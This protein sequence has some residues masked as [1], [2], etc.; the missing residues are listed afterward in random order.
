[1]HDNNLLKRQ[2]DD[3]LKKKKL[4]VYTVFMLMCIYLL[5]NILFDNN[6]VIKYFELKK[7]EQKLIFEIASL[8]KENDMIE[9]EIQLLRDNPFYF[10][11]HARENLNLAGPN[12]F[13]FLYEQ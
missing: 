3:E 13:I 7:N 11:K 4:V 10:E 9:K 5:F 6:G 2:I 1:M 12:E 8:Q